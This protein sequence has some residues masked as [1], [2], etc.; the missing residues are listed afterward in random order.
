MRNN[1]FYQCRDGQERRRDSTGPGS[2]NEGREAP[3][4]GD[5]IKCGKCGWKVTEEKQRVAVDGSHAH[6]FFNPAGVV[7][8]VGCFQRAAGCHLAGAATSEFTWFAGY[9]W[10]YALCARCGSHLGWFYEG[11]SMSF[12][13][14]ILKNITG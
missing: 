1:L 7:F 8:E 11:R 5:A 9:L 10:R 2:E 12:Y 14:L 6:T 3:G 13:G 4:S